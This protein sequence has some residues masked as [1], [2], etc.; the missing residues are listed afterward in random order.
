MKCDRNRQ[1]PRR[2][3]LTKADL[4]TAWQ[5]Q[6]LDLLWNTDDDYIAL[7]LTWQFCHHLIGAYGHPDRS[8]GKKLMSTMIDRLR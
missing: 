8:R 4:C 3:L 1:K 2:G 5:R 6:H 7:P